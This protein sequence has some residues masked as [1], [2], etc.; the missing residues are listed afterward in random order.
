MKQMALVGARNVTDPFDGLLRGV[1]YLILDPNHQGLGSRIIRW[2]LPARLSARNPLMTLPL[3]TKTPHPLF[4]PIMR[5]AG[6]H[7]AKKEK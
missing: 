2:G 7:A 3:Q 4:H 1:R 6:P 5:A